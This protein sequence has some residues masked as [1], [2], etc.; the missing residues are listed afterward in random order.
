MQWYNHPNGYLW[1]GHNETPAIFRVL[2]LRQ[3]NTA[4]FC[5]PNTGARFQAV[6]LLPHQG[7]P[8]SKAVAEE[9]FETLDEAKLWCEARG[10][11][12]S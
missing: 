1:L 9:R 7:G 3:A 2:D 12:L 5:I 4:I 8:G 6:E 10:L 11:L